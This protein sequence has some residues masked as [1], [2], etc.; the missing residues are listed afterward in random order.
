MLDFAPERIKRR[1]RLQPGRMFLVDTA[2]GRIVED[3][4]IKKATLAA[5]EPWDLLAASASTVGAA[6]ARSIVHPVASIMRRQRTFDYTEEEVR[7]LLTPMGQHGVE[8]L[9]AM[10]SDTPIAVLSKRPRLLFDYFAQQFA[11]VTNPP[12]DSIR[13]EVVTSLRASLGGERN[14]AVVGSR[15][16]PAGHAGLPGHR[17]RRAGEDQNIGRTMPDCAAR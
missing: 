17:Q 9:G 11:Q 3:E 6:R 1:E 14:P 13:E 15:P 16:R 4:E 10:G 8:A 12:L 5:Q 7:I 2:Q